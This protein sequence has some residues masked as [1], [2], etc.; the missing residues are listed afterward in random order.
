MNKAEKKILTIS[1]ILF[2][3]GVF[4]RFIP[5][6]LP[7]IDQLP[8]QS[9]LEY[10]SAPVF[11]TESVSLKAQKIKDENQALKIE[12]KE[13][14]AKK[15]QKKAK[16]V[17]FPI[18]INSATKDE[19]C[20]LKGVGEALA[21]KILAYKDQNGPYLNPDDLKKVPGIGNKKLES[22]LQGIIFD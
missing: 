18:H 7:T 15:T 20:A 17:K 4:V 8:E 9:N 14:K 11:S 12:K 6:E 16:K 13:K 3:I 1:T 19:L 22:I 5:W 21:E 2:F 10:T